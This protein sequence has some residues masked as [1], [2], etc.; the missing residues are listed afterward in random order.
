MASHVG[1]LTVNELL[2]QPVVLS[3]AEH[4]HR[5]I[6]LLEKMR[7]YELFVVEKG[8]VKGLLTIRGVLKTRSIAGSKVSSLITRVPHLSRN[9]TVSTAARIMTDYRV[10]AVPIVEDGKLAGQIAASSICERMAQ[11]RK[12]NVKA[13]ALMTPDPVFLREGDS[14]AKARTVM[15]QRNIDHI[16]VLRERKIAGVVTSDAIVFRMAPAESITPESIT[17]EKQARLDVS[18]S[19]LI[20]EP[21][22]STLDADVCQVIEEMR[23]RG[24][25]YSLVALWDELQG[26][27]TYRDCVKLLTET[28]EPSLPISIVGLPEDPFEA[29]SAKRKFETVVKRL[30]RSLPDLLEA[31]SVIKTSVRAGQ[32][33]R[34]EVEVELITPRKTTSFSA[35]GWSLPEVFDELSDRMKRVTTKKRGPRKERLE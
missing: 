15:T 7:T 1:F 19:G 31:R 22:I 20:A 30:A 16:P 3:P 4:V 8:E 26:I 24:T 13:S 10:R 25:A 14:V 32:R 18:V 33:H 28:A 23:R 6:G 27:I 34:Y 29:E 9:D 2:T 35:S 21:V 5:A 17:S 11:E 12:L